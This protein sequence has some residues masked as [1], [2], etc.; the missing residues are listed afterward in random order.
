MGYLFDGDNWEWLWTENNA[1]FLLEAFLVNV[2]IAVIA[3]VLALV[4]GLGLALASIAQARLVRLTA[5]G[6]V[7]VFRNLPLIFLILYLALSLPDSLKDFWAANAPGF[8]PEAL[9]GKLV[10]AG[11]IGLVLYNS[12]VLAEIMR[13]GIL[14]LDRGQREAAAALG[15]SYRQQMRHVLLPQGLRRMVPATVSQLITLNKDTTLVSIIAVQE[16]VRSGRV[17][18]NTAGNP[19][20]GGGDIAAPI[21]QVMI[22][23]GLLFV[24]VN[25][26]LSRLSRRLELREGRRTAGARRVSVSG[27]EDQ[28]VAP[29]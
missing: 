24:L 15:L 18:S 3:I 11:I 25:L 27:I 19:F 8:L 1:S 23:I 5:K 10:L 12:A 22:F 9:R 21:L 29:T 16:V 4:L 14:S 2:E 17:L 26:A 13:A 28:A 20:V 6:W 7:D